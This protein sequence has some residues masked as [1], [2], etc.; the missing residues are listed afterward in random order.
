MTTYLYR[1]A[2]RCTARDRFDVEKS[3]DHAGRAE[4]CPACGG[5][6]IRIFAVGKQIMRP[7]GW[8]LRPGDAG[9]ADFR[10]AGELGEVRNPDGK[11]RLS[12]GATVSSR[13][14]NEPL[15]YDE[16]AL[17]NFY[18]AGRQVYSDMTGEPI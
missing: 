9:Y 5:A 7:T 15:R 4:S 2:A 17:Q 11:S 16:Q 18:E 12:R 1:C 13:L 14:Q 3:P 8:H 6:A 10:R